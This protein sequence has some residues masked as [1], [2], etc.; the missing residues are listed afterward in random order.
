MTKIADN[1]VTMHLHRTHSLF[2]IFKTLLV[3]TFAPVDEI[4]RLLYR[5]IYHTENISFLPGKMR[6]RL[7]LVDSPLLMCDALL[8]LSWLLLLQTRIFFIPSKVQLSVTTYSP[9]HSGFI[10]SPPSCIKT[11]NIQ[12]LNL[13]QML[14]N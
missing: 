1:L 3:L 14:H 8:V 5:K 4:L 10:F 2:I 13:N 11:Y 12:N 7:G 6:H 9:R